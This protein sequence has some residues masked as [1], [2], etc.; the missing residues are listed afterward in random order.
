MEGPTRAWRDSTFRAGGGLALAAAAGLLACPRALADTL[1][2][3]EDHGSIQAAID[4][5]EPGDDVI[6]A[7]GTYRENLVLRAEID[8]RGA[9]TARTLLAPDDGDVAIVTVASTNGVRLSS[10]TLIEGSLGVVVQASSGIEIANVVFDRLDT[11]VTVDGVSSVDL[12][13]NVF[14]RNETA[15]SRGSALT[16][17][18]N[19]IFEGNGSTLATVLLP[20]DDQSAN[21]RTNCF[22]DNGGGAEGNGVVGTTFTEGEPLFVDPERRDFHLREGSECIDVGRGTDAIDGSVAD[23]GAYGGAL[24]DP[25]PFPIAAP[26]LTDV[27]AAEPPSLNVEIRWEPNLDHRVT[28][29]VLPGG[30]RVHYKRGGDH[31]PPFDGTDAEA[32]TNP[33]PIDVGDVTSYVLTGLA[34]ETSTPLAPRGLAAEGRN[35]SVVLTWEAAAGATGYRVHYG[36]ASVD[37]NAV[38]TGDV[39]TYA[40]TGLTNGTAF[41]FAVSALNQPLY[42]I[43]VTA[44]DNTQAANESAIA[45]VATIALGAGTESPRSA[46]ASATAEPLAPYPDLPDEGCFIATAAFGADWAP[47]V[48]VLRELRDRL[49]AR[50]SAGRFLIRGYY[51]LSP[52]AARFIREHD[53]LRPLVRAALWPAVAGALLLLEAPAALGLGGAVVAL[54]V[55]S[56]RRRRSATAHAGHGMLFGAAL[57]LLGAPVFAQEPNA[58]VSPRWMYEVKGGYFYPALDD[59]GVFYGDDRDTFFAVAGAYRLREWLEVGAEIGHLRD[60]GAAVA[61]GGVVEDAVRLRLV[62]LRVFATFIWQDAGRRFVPYGGIGL[63]ATWYDQDVQLEPGRD[64]RSD[65]GA[66]IHAGVRWFLRQEGSRGAAARR[67]DTWFSRTFVFFEAQKSETEIDAID[68]GGEAFTIGFRAELELGRRPR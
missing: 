5:A 64:G 8:V 37:E 25:L 51:A 66:S 10:F 63:A 67:T 6:V 41:R 39:T 12:T 4:E 60:R 62:P 50:H 15:V 32:G 18:D 31:A 36:I 45:E 53:W 20:G 54:V 34:V 57:L 52:P 2:V 27:S 55:W 7:P 9:E 22:F 16:E 40:V 19:N 28:N 23:T 3:P 65:V 17:I 13:N 59:Y 26:T 47:Q 46:E 24:A 43:A 49:L 58:S 44:I 35:E 42:H 14:F 68:L 11:A 33:S 48:L 29:S 56:R 1:R 30:Y 61:S 21:V 38:E